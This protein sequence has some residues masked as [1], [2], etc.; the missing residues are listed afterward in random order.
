[1]PSVQDV[2]LVIILILLV[3]VL[4][5]LLAQQDKW[6]TLHV[7]EMEHQILVFVLFVVLQ[8]LLVAQHLPVVSQLVFVLPVSQDIT[9][10][11]RPEHALPVKQSPT[12]KGQLAPQEQ[13]QLVP[14]VT[15]VTT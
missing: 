13:H 1:M 12:A 3:P 9:S 10:V 2:K 6:S 8:I 11:L 14:I 15:K 7:L 4:P 5:V